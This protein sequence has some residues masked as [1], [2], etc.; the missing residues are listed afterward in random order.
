[1][2]NEDDWGSGHAWIVCMHVNMHVM[3]GMQNEYTYTQVLQLH[4]CCACLEN[5]VKGVLTQVK[6][7]EE[8]KDRVAEDTPC[9]GKFNWKL[10]VNLRGGTI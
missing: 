6:G 1:M 4:C 3:E 5:A 10:L 2:R 9:V 7:G 8:A